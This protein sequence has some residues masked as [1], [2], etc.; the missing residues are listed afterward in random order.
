MR[1]YE[2]AV[3]HFSLFGGTLERCFEFFLRRVLVQLRLSSHNKMLGSCPPEKKR[4]IEK[5]K[6]TNANRDP[7][8]RNPHFSVTVEVA[9][10]DESR[11]EGLRARL[12]NAKS[13][14]GIDRKISSTQNADLLE[15]LLSYFEIMKPSTVVARSFSVA[16]AESGPSEPIQPPPSSIESLEPRRPQKRQIYVDATEDDPCFICTGESLKSMAKYFTNNPQCEFCGEDYKWSG[17]SFSKQG[18]V[19]RFQLPCVGGDSV[20]WLSSGVLGYP[21]KYLANVR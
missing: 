4:R 5:N 14:L 15:T 17:L 16:S 3:V 10:G 21:T 9:M 12:N 8:K 20:I 1:V 6:R 7:S 18:H 11:L 13:L 19:C 2:Y